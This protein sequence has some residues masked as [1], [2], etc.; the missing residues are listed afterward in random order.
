MTVHFVML[1]HDDPGH[2]GR[3]VRQLDFPDARVWLHVDAKASLD[4]WREV[5]TAPN[6][7]VVTPR[8]R[9]SWGTFSLVEATLAAVR[10]ALQ[11]AADDDVLVL[12]SGQAYPVKSTER[13]KS[14]FAANS[15]RVLMDVRRIEDAWPD[16]HRTRCYHYPLSEVTGDL[17]LTKPFSE[18]KLRERRG[19]FLR[20]VRRLG[21]RRALQLM[22]QTWPTGRAPVAQQYGG[23]QWWGLPAGIARTC[24]AFHDAHPEFADYYRWSQYP[25]ELYFQNLLFAAVPALRPTDCLP[26]PMYVDWTPGDWSLPRVFG[27]ED[28][29]K[30]V[31]QGETVLFARKF[32]SDRSS[33]LLDR[34]DAANGRAVEGPSGRDVGYSHHESTQ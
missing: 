27:N 4:D 15:G 9:C 1:A 20:L 34:P 19:M 3:L 32:Y 16:D 23:S 11:V 13:I 25:D 10:S 18:M 30:L 21:P 24:L 33:E 17:A 12:L 22:R 5:T 7:T 2:V 6:V 28:F 26:S 31:A 14:Y 8:T 29:E